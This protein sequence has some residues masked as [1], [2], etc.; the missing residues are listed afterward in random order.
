MA[1]VQCKKLLLMG[2]IL[3][4]GLLTFR[5]APPAAKNETPFTTTSENPTTDNTTT[6]TP[7][8]QATP[9]SAHVE[10]CVDQSGSAPAGSQLVVYLEVALPQQ[11][12]PNLIAQ[13][14]S[15]TAQT[16]INSMQF[17]F[18]MNHFN[19]RP[20]Y[21]EEYYLSF[22][23]DDTTLAFYKLNEGQSVDLRMNKIEISVGSAKLIT[24][25]ALPTY[26]L[27]APLTPC[28][29]SNGDKDVARFIKQD[30]TLQ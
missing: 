8:P 22:L 11:D 15:T 30:I 16:S 4:I 7:T 27:L 9:L 10:I 3:C 25:G 26:R 5:C 12:F 24:T 6:P 13:P 28:L 1:V 29:Q 21:K 23:K 17:A 19:P 14:N 2:G 18:A 20:G